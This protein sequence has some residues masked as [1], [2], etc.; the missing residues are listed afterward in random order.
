MPRMPGHLASLSWNRP[1]L[2]HV[3]DDTRASDDFQYDAM[4]LMEAAD[5]CSLRAQMALCVALYETVAWRFDGLHDRAEPLQV[6]EAGWIGTLD[7]RLLADLDL[8]RDRWT[9]PVFGP[10]WCGAIWLW[11]ALKEGDAQLPEVADALDYLA[12][13]A[14]HVAPEPR[15][16]VAWLHRV[17]DRL[18]QSHPAQPADPFGDLFDRHIGQR[19]GPV[20]ARALFDEPP[21]PPG[22]PGARHEA[23]QAL[24]TQLA[25]RNPLLT[26]HP[27]PQWTA[28]LHSA[29]RDANP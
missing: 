19:R 13:L 16:L 8:G 18:R 29:G 2:H 3:W 24:G 22:A 14:V 7:P 23:L 28:W 21:A 26:A 11:P 12:R 6:L 20:V 1:S 10:L 25:L 15:A 27:D 17:V 4:W 9:G 5:P